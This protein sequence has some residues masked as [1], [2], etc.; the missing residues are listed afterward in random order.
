MAPK[1]V[2][3]CYVFKSRLQEYAQKAGLMTPVYETIK[4]GPS[5]QPSFRS[6]VVLNNVRYDSLPGFFNRKAAEQSAAEVALVEL[7]NSTTD[8]KFGISQS[9]HETGLCKNLLQEYAQ[10]LNYAVPLYECRKEEKQGRTPM[11]SCILEI[12]G[13]KYIGASASTKKEAEIKTART[14]LLAIQS[15]TSG[16]ENHNTGGNS[17]Y[18]VLP[19]KKKVDSDLGISTQETAAALKPKKGR[20]KKKQWK[21]KKQAAYKRGEWPPQSTTQAALESELTDVISSQGKDSEV[22]H[23]ET[24]MNISKIGSES[25]FVPID[26]RVCKDGES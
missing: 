2:A 1:G 8:T 10:K 17:I 3:S 21:N 20:F 15:A 26:E 7:A 18:T 14:A 11:Y 24:T 4:E 9:V 6:T 12:G 5:H 19:Q 16:S 23:S 25:A 13:I 22:G